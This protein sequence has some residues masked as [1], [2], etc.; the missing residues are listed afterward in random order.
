MPEVHFTIQ[1]P[2]GTPRT[3]YSPSS[4]VLRHFEAGQEL[5]V[6]EFVRESRLALT[7]ASDRV[8]QKFG[9]G[10]T[11]AAAQMQEIEQFTATQPPEG[12][13]RILTI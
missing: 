3:C 9:F 1:L 8:R 12:I 13:V 5:T 10:C 7:E 11:A 4:V 6:A 2:D